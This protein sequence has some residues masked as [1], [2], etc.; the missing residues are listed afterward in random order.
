MGATKTIVDIS[1][2]DEIHSRI[3]A[4]CYLCGT[5]GRPLYESLADRLYNA[6]GSW[7]LKR[8][9]KSECG[10]LWLDPMPTE[11]DIHK[12]YKNYFT[13][14]GDN[15]AKNG[16]LRRVYGHAKHGYWASKYGYCEGSAKNIWQK[17]IGRAI[18]LDPGLSAE[19]DFN[20]MY[21]RQN[22]NGKLLD[23]GCGSGHALQRMAELGWAVYGVD[24]DHTAVSIA[25]KRGLNV[26]YGT[27]ESKGYPSDYFDA[28]TMSH[29]IEHIHDPLSLLNE[30]RRILKRGGRLVIVT[31]NSNSWGHKKF[32]ANWMHLDP[33][34]H[35]HI[36]NKQSLSEL[37][38]KS[39]FQLIS[40]STTIRD[41]NGLF[42]GSRS[43]ARTGRYKMGRVERNL[44]HWSK[45]MQLV[46]R[47][48]MKFEP[49]LG[50][51]IALVG[52]K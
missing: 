38:I 10:L 45:G 34:R 20:V 18:Q 31:P 36:F 21:L 29:V 5:A 13:H 26:S 3:C 11:E 22:R 32:R 9:P 51:E 7:N 39:G 27:L 4:T 17:L 43:I 14:L 24:F 52:E 6:S 49:D 41:A 44:F 33:P 2:E 16:W 19:L 42:I 1:S 15:G 25:Q 23:V 12:A 46:E 35:L 47:L 50:E 8:C 37:A 30:C 40:K 28:I 48:R